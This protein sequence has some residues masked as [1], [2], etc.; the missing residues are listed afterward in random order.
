MHRA[1]EPLG[2]RL[3]STLHY[4]AIHPGALF[5]LMLAANAIAWPFRA[6]FH[7][8]NLYGFQILHRLA[9]ERHATD[10]FVQYGSQDRYSLFSTL[11]APLAIQV[12]VPITLFLLYVVSKGLFLVAVQRL[13]CVLVK[14]P[15]TAVLASLFVAVAPLPFGGH[16]VFQV[17]E[18]FFTPRLPATAL[19]L[20]ALERCL[21][22]RRLTAAG[23]ALVALPLHPLMAFPGLLIVLT[24]V[25][26][27]RL[28]GKR[29]AALL[30]AA[31]VVLL[32][33]FLTPSV[34]SHLFG[35]MT[36][37]WQTTVLMVNSY[38][39]PLQWDLKD[40][41]RIGLT[42]AAAI[43]VL[44]AL[45]IDDPIRRLIQAIV[46]VAAGGLAFAIVACQFPYALPLQG[47]AYRWAWPLE[48]LL[49]PLGFLLIHRLWTAETPGSQAAALAGLTYL[50]L[51]PWE[52]VFVWIPAVTAIVF[53]FI[54][55]RGTGPTPREANWLRHTAFLGL[56]A[57]CL[58]ITVIR[59][60]LFFI[61]RDDL[62]PS[63]DGLDMIT[64]ATRHTAPILWVALLLL[65]ASCVFHRHPRWLTPLA[66]STAFAVLFTLLVLP[67]TLLRPDRSGRFAEDLC[68]VRDYLAERR[69]PGPAPTVYW[70]VMPVNY[71]WF[72]LQANGYFSF[73]HQLSG[74]LFSPGTAAE[75]RRRALIVR[76]YEME[77][78]QRWERFSPPYQITRNRLLFAAP[79]GD[80]GPP[81]REDFLELC[82]DPRVDFAILAHRY[83][84]IRAT[85]NGRVFIY[86]CRALRAELALTDPQ[87]ADA[88][89]RRSHTSP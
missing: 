50:N 8:A 26:W 78:L 6:Y 83:D 27:D 52:S 18:H 13:V 72:E 82:A 73:P 12:G 7:D 60:A 34:A 41:G 42:F 5:A 23:L 43:L 25:L 10:L 47:Q 1:V 69:S 79:T 44:R 51:L 45:P 66:A 28:G 31:A 74:N 14:D 56:V 76:R 63:L 68:F 80:P 9:P 55:W 87:F 57:A 11:A 53:G 16:G 77:R 86:D 32:G 89:S 19:V 59:Y 62:A 3:S 84:G 4:L 15:R 20:F 58:P 40:W 64:S 37:E 33:I 81:T 38:N 39:F 71:V 70:P 54:R 67:L 24:C 65:A 46:L 36:Q 48:M 88:G 85:E 2:A 61:A 49:I 29:L 30:V 17:N 22:G 35:T 75:G 21:V